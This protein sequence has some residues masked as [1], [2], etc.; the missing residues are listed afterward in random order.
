M[1]EDSSEVVV[2][3]VEDDA[4]KNGFLPPAVSNGFF[5]FCSPVE[6]IGECDFKTD[7]DERL[8]KIG[9]GVAEETVVGH[10]RPFRPSSTAVVVT[11]DSASTRDATLASENVADAGFTPKENRALWDEIVFWS[12]LDCDVRGGLSSGVAENW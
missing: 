3:V 6:R 2:V 1:K 7:S 10:V 5:T 9:R 4:C 11:I 12:S 8:E